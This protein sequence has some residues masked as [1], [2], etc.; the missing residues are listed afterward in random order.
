MQIACLA[1][2][3]S[4]GNPQSPSF[5]VVHLLSGV[6]A[7]VYTL[8]QPV[9]FAAVAP[10]QL[11]VEPHVVPFG[12]GVCSD[13]V[14]VLLPALISA[15]TVMG[16]GNRTQRLSIARVLHRASCHTAPGAGPAKSNR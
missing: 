7:V 14:A 9:S 12:F 8:F 3:T 2:P 11:V 4:I 16:G 6:V 15:D 13:L 1:L 10:A 5:P